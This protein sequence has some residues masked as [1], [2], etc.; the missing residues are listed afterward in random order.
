MYISLQFIE[1]GDDDDANDNSNNKENNEDDR[2]NKETIPYPVI[3]VEAVADAEASAAD[4]R[5]RR[6]SEF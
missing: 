2:E 6:S 1:Y 5:I 3:V 4:S